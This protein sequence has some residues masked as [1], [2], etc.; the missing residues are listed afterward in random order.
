MPKRTRW[1]PLPGQ[2]RA[3]GEGEHGLHH[4]SPV[5]G[6]EVAHKRREALAPY[7]TRSW[8]EVFT[9]GAWKR[10]GEAVRTTEPDPP[11]NIHIPNPT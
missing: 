2:Y 9:D 10:F 8:V 5:W 3:A 7:V 4:G 1:D 11:T 6:L